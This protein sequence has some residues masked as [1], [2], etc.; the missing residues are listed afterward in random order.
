MRSLA[1]AGEGLDLLPER[2]EIMLLH[3]AA[4]EIRATQREGPLQP[5]STV[6]EPA[7]AAG[8]A[9]QI[10]RNGGDIRK[11]VADEEKSV[12][13]IFSLPHFVQ[14][15]GAVDPGGGTF[16]G[17]IEQCR[18]YLHADA[19]LSRFGMDGKSHFENI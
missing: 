10:I 11:L 13:G 4:L 8:V 9:S 18:G 12:P 7:E 6:I 16:R 3:C 19:P 15:K 2:L 14:G 5:G 17:E 1:R